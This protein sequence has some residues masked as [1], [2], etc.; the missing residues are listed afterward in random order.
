VALAPNLYLHRPLLWAARR[1]SPD[2]LLGLRKGGSSGLLCSASFRAWQWR[3]QV[4][5]RLQQSLVDHQPLNARFITESDSAIGICFER[6]EMAFPIQLL[7]P[8]IRAY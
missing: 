4:H 3:V 2:W 7:P 8:A 5:I 1:G 6:R